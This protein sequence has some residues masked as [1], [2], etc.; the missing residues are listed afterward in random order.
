MNSLKPQWGKKVTNIQA[1]VFKELDCI[2]LIM[3]HVILALIIGRKTQSKLHKSRQPPLLVSRVRF[4]LII[5]ASHMSFC[6][7]QLSTPCEDESSLSPKRTVTAQT[8][9]GLWE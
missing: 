5:M 1:F 7:V 9:L 6:I 4:I 2:S 8:I 3:K